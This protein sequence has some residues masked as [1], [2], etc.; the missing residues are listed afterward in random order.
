VSRRT[1][2]RIVQ[3]ELNDRS[4]I[5]EPCCLDQDSRKGGN[6][7][8]VPPNE[9]VRQ[10]LLQI[11]AQRAAYAA[12]RQYRY[13]PVDRFDQQM[14]KSNLAEFV[15]DDGTVSHAG[16]TQQLVEQGRL[17]AAEKAGNHRDGEPRCGSVRIE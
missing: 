5:G 16:V 6:L 12:A 7:G 8:A 3:K 17:A 13:L 11:A 1:K 15:D 4:W 14:I 2:Y 9:Q 10:R